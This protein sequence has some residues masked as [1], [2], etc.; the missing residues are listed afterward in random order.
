MNDLHKAYNVLG[1][2]P[3]TSLEAILRRYKRLI[4][5][6]HPDRFPT[7]DAKK[8]AEEELKKINNAKDKLKDHFDNGGHKASGPCACKAEQAGARSQTEGTYSGH[9]S[10]GPG[11]GQRRKTTE[12]QQREEEAAKRRSEERR[13]QQETEA[14]QK[15]EQ[16]AKAQAQASQQQAFQ[17]AMQYDQEHRHDA[18]RWKISV[19]C[20]ALSILLMV[21]AIA[22]GAIESGIIAAQNA[23]LTT[24]EEAEASGKRSDEWSKYIDDRQKVATQVLRRPVSM[25]EAADWKPPYSSADPSADPISREF[26][27]SVTQAEQQQQKQHDQDIYAGKMQVDKYEKMIEHCNSELTQ[28]EIKIAD[29]TISGDERNK[30]I[31]LRDFRRQNLQEAQAGLQD[32]RQK[33]RELLGANPPQLLSPLN[34][35]LFNTDR[36]GIPLVPLPSR[37]GVGGPK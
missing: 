26:Y 8:D 24:H 17:Q 14:Q 15:A 30:L 36:S 10:A 20:G 32:S 18:L 4:M 7:E 31:N 1:L 29:P 5:V 27:Q 12:E 9:S 11:P 6:W 35:T 23:M 37:D 16:Q 3:G 33:L 34:T 25:M 22:V 21:I 28:I 13:R 19:A 2:E